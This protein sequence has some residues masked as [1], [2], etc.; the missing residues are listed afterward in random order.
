[1]KI[2]RASHLGMC[3][4]VR[5]AIQLATRTARTQPVTILGQLVHNQTVVRRLLAAGARMA[6][7]PG[8][9]RT[10]TVMISAHGA[11]ERAVAALR[12]RGLEVLEATCPLVQVAHL[13]V[14]RLERD[15]YH[16]VIV[17]Q[18]DHVE[19]RGLTGD[20]AAFDVVLSEADVTQLAPR[21]RFGVA[22][23]TTQPVARVRTLAEAIRRRFPN[24]PVKLVDT[25]CRPTK[26]RQAAAV[27]LAQTTDAVVIIGGAASNN[28]RELVATCAQHCPRVHHVQAADDLCA[29][30]F[31]AS[32][33]VGIT[34]GTSTP[35]ETIDE[36]ERQL[37]AWADASEALHTVSHEVESGAALAAH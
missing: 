14:R 11:S 5:D 28:T 30:W 36:V 3:F 34:A 23:Q 18:R 7:S 16:P 4:G 8:E 19:V 1:M 35:D 25:V 29:D 10:S 37:R 21:P 9:V 6:E 24:S 32:D 20:L 27:Q 31:H 17:G 15:G 33:V 12:G 22:A 13:A 26:D 2:L